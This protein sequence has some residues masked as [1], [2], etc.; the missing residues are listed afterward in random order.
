MPVI[1]RDLKMT[2]LSYLFPWHTEISM[3]SKWEKSCLSNQKV[4]FVSHLYVEF[5]KQNRGSKGEGRE[6]QNK[7]KSERKTN[8]KR[9]LIMGNKLRVHRRGRG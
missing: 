2:F 3:Y 7:T 4:V 1:Q 6:K 5:K 8:Y 9:V